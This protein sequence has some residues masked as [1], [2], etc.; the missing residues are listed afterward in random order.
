MN[1]A[2]TKSQSPKWRILAIAIVF[3]V[4]IAAVYLNT[5]QAN[6]AQPASPTPT[7]SN[8]ISQQELEEKYGLRV[9]LMAVT[10]AGGFVD[11]RLKVLDTEKAGQLLNDPAKMPVLYIQESGWI[12]KQPADEQTTVPKLEQDGLLLGLFPNSLNAVKPGTPITVIF[13]DLALEPIV[14][15]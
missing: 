9:M 4:A 14:S 10:G 15:Q 1:V 7:I 11:F 12:L 5:A 13:G 3:L 6:K 8:T 2:D